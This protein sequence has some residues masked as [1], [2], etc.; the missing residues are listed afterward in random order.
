MN[1]LYLRDDLANAW[2]AL[3]PFAQIDRLR[4]RVF[5][6]V[7]G[8]TTMRVRLDSEVLFLKRHRGVGWREILKNLLSLRLPVLGA[9]NEFRAAR[10][11]LAA[12]VAVPE[13]VAYAERGS[14]PARRDSFLLST[15]H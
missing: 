4:G 11:L 9:G 10:A 6:D 2:G 8:R 7:A 1:E 13:P 5:R 12:G 3:D 15:C 14:N